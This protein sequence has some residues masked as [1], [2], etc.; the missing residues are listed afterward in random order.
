VADSLSYRSFDQDLIDSE[1]WK[2]KENIIA[3][4]G[5]PKLTSTPKALL[6]NLEEELEDL[7]MRVNQ[8]ILAGDNPHIKFAGKNND[9]WT[10]PYTKEEESARID[11]FGYLPP[12]GLNT[13]L[14]L[15]NRHCSFS[16]AFSHAIGRYVKKELNVS[17]LL[18]AL[19]ACATN[20]G[21]TKMARN[22]NVSQEEIHQA[23]RDY[24]RPETLKLACDVIVDSIRDLPLFSGWH[25]DGDSVYSSSDGQKFGVSRDTC[26]ARYSS[27]YFGLDKGIVSY[28][29]NANYLPI[30]SRI[31]GANEHESH[32]V[33]DILLDNTSEVRPNIHTTDSHG[34]NS[35]NFALLY[36]FDYVFAPRYRNLPEAAKNIYCFGDINRYENKPLRPK[37]KI[38]RALVEEDWDNV[39]RISVSLATKTTSQS[40]IVR[41][42]SSYPMKNK[43]RKALG[44]LDKAIKSIH[45]LRYIDE[46]EF[47]QHIQKALNRGESYHSLKRAVFYDN[48]GKFRVASEHEQG[49]WSECSR[50]LALSIIYYNS[51]ILSQIATRQTNLGLKSG[52]LQEISPIQWKHIDLFGQ[53]YFGDFPND[54]EVES[55][56]MAIEKLDFTLFCGNMAENT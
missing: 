19:T 6:D 27:K 52:A 1:S 46:L 2:N 10:L 3:S 55:V 33:L 44:E 11:I 53:F 35:I 26:N 32:F 7:Y 20:M 36:L 49:I 41:K 28:T 51:F 37:G 54:N 25:V 17:S 29:L 9:K 34:T 23:Y 45:I 13:L 43:T 22:A 4:L 42:L 48:L 21:L 56:L 47:R 50:L 39:R 38:D 40:T 14:N 12:V 15:V 18:A 24:I 30:N 5:L 31:I 8:R 16:S